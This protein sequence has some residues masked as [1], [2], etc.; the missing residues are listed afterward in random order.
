M[1]N[2]L[3]QRKVKQNFLKTHHAFI[4][5]TFRKITLTLNIPSMKIMQLL[6]LTDKIYQPRALTEDR[7]T[8]TK[9]AA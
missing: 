1:C 6:K 8:Q 2:I 9:L 5:D 3:H 4:A 7:E